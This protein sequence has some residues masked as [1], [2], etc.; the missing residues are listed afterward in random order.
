MSEWVK[1]LLLGILSV[2]FGIFVLGNTFAASIAVTVV[3]GVVF[4]ISGGLQ[5]FAGFGADGWGGKLLGV[6]LGIL[7]VFIGVSFMAHPLQGLISL[8]LLVTILLAAGGITRIIF[9]FRLRETQYFWMMLI[10]GALSVLLAAIIISG[11]Y[12]AVPNILGIMLGIELLFNGS[13]LIA[14]SLV[15]RKGGNED[16]A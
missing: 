3:T 9:A 10:S 15:I 16:S 4:L 12:Q 13:G 1:W 11:W 2:V 7:M 6:L 14:M 5:V 8:T